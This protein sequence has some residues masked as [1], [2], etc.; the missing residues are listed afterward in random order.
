MDVRKKIGRICL[1]GL[2]LAILLSACSDDDSATANKPLYRVIEVWAHTGSA[3]HNRAL[4]EQVARF[5]NVQ[6]EIRVNV[7][8]LPRKS[9]E[10][11]L[12]TAAAN[13]RLPDIIEVSSPYIYQYAENGALQP[14][15]KW[16]M[17]E[18]LEQFM[19]AA[20]R[21]GMYHGRLYAVMP[22]LSGIVMFANRK[23]LEQAGIRLPAPDHS[24]SIDTFNRNL[25][26][27]ARQDSDGAVLD[28]QLYRGGNW[29]ASVMLPMLS[30]AGGG[31]IMHEPPDRFVQGLDNK[32]T[33]RV[34]STVQRWIHDGYVVDKPASFVNGDVAFMVAEH[35]TF[36][37]YYTA[38]GDDL[39]V[40]PLPDFGHGAKIAL[41][42]WAW[43]L[44]SQCHDVQASMHLLEFLLRDE[45]VVATADATGAMPALKSALVMAEDYNDSGELAMMPALVSRAAMMPESSVYPYIARIFQQ[46]FAKIH[47]KDDVGQIMAKAA[48]AADKVL[49]GDRKKLQGRL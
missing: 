30:S 37:Q 10:E 8:I 1:A 38:L 16:L 46:A 23:L 12:A 40:M 33:L 32:N 22:T 27:L 13:K 49:S 35:Q 19:P 17:E 5:N 9:Y 34:L 6:H 18:D 47:R 20:V 26:T 48:M 31:L 4:Q 29:P 11:Q 45:E 36:W 42:A 28:M 41:D 44:T 14:L 3:E 21:Q 2:C 39:V 7:V 43:G 25:A 15:D 24:W